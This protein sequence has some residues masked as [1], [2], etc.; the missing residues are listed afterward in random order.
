MQCWHDMLNHCHM[1]I[2]A[3]FSLYSVLP[4]PGQQ[5]CLLHLTLE[6]LHEQSRAQNSLRCP[7]G[8]ACDEQMG[9]QGGKP[10]FLQGVVVGLGNPTA[11]SADLIPVSKAHSSHGPNCNAHKLRARQRHAAN[12]VLSR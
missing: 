12:W 8:K 1:L 11:V 7:A 2:T 10:A 5:H 9:S 3:T 6:V 4:A